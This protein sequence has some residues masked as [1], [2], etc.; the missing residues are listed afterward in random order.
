MHNI[1]ADSGS[2][3]AELDL[4]QITA[5]VESAFLQTQ[6]TVL[7]KELDDLDIKDAE[8][9][10]LIQNLSVDELLSYLQALRNAIAHHLRLNNKDIKVKDLNIELL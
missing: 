5:S 1:F 10:G 3:D 9:K 7:I 4:Q 8:L 2:V 6:K